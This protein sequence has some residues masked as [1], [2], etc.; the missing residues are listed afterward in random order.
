M[1][2]FLNED[3]RIDDLEI[4]GLKLI[5]KKND[6]CFSSDAVLL[7]NFVKAK[8]SDVVVDFGT[9][10]G[11]ISILIAAK[12]NASKV[13]GI[14]LQKS[15]AQLAEKNV[16]FNNLTDKVTIYN[17]DI[18]NAEN[19]LGKESV[20]IVV[21]NP[22]YFKAT[23]GEVSSNEVK[24]ISRTE[25]K[26][27]LEEIIQHA[28][29]VLKYSGKLYMIHKSERLA[30]VLTTM[31]NNNLE[32]KKI[33]FIYP[34]KSKQVDTFIVEAQ[35]YGAPGVCISSFVVYEENG[36]MTNE[37]KKLYNKI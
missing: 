20:S 3:E 32:P 34:K 23:S 18:K 11:I 17:D 9:G 33:T 27:T 35:K 13:M 24:A 7:A 6:Y 21:C 22:P 2:N 5:Q 10:S 19:I 26:I 12:T 37:A 14:E 29:V 15:M 30:E 31:S 16:K 4:K 1:D 8:K 25:L 28:A 36:E